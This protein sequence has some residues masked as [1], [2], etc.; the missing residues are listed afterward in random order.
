[1]RI[2]SRDT[3]RVT[4]VYGRKAKQKSYPCAAKPRSDGSRALAL[5]LDYLPFFGYNI[6]YENN[7]VNVKGIYVNG[8]KIEGNILPLL[9]G[10]VD[11]KVIT[12]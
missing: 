11:V 12:E 8:E 10:E 3:L 2:A 1:M 4:A 9:K 5:A 6:S 7:G